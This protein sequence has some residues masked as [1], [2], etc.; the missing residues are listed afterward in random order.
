[1]VIVLY[2]LHILS[3]FISVLQI[4]SSLIY[5]FGFTVHMNYAALLYSKNN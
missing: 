4:C 1:M 3:W 5:S 2:F